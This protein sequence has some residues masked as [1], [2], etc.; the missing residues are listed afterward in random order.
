M[1]SN[2]LNLPEVVITFSEDLLNISIDIYEPIECLTFTKKL[3][4]SYYKFQ[5]KNK[6]S[7]HTILY[8]F[9]GSQE[10]TQMT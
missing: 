10:I 3:N 9:L 6:K 4:D 7:S 1:I 5:D 8:A 2:K